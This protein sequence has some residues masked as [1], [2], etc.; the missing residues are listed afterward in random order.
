MSWSLSCFVVDNWTWM[1]TAQH[2]D[3]GLMRSSHSLKCDETG[4]HKRY[5]FRIESSHSCPVLPVNKRSLFCQT[6]KYLNSAR[7]GVPDGGWLLAHI[8]RS[9]CRT[10][11]FRIGHTL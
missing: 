3:I 4:Y 2:P 10:I 7:G 11:C 1:E 5:R 8:A 9:D 6:C